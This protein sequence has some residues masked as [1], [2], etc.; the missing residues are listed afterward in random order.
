MRSG[1]EAS[2][3]LE[4]GV[5]ELVGDV[6]AEHAELAPL[7]QHRVEKT[8]RKQQLLVPDNNAHRAWIETQ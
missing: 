8:E 6:P 5:V 3:D 4:V 2:T 7:Q 1:G